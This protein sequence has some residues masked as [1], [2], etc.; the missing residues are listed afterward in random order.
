VVVNEWH[1]TLLQLLPVEELERIGIDRDG[2]GC[3]LCM[4]GEES[5]GRGGRESLQLPVAASG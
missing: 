5:E 2:G 4:G 3:S 1:V